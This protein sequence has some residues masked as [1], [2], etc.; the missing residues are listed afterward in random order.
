MPF[1]YNLH[2]DIRGQSYK[3][4]IVM[5][6]PLEKEKTVS[7]EIVARHVLSFR[8]SYLVSN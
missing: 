1:N 7:S 6:I 5:L 8:K 2:E 3:N 4:I